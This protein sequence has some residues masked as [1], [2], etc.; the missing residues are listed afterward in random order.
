MSLNDKYYY[1]Y[2]HSIDK[3]MYH[4]ET[5]KLSQPYKTVIME[6]LN[7]YAGLLAL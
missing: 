4:R 1:H 7:I 2:C 6:Q 5:K 3:K